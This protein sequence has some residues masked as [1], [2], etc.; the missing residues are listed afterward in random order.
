SFVTNNIDHVQH[1]DNQVTNQDI[2]L[3]NIIETNITKDYYQPLSFDQKQQEQNEQ[4]IVI[5]QINNIQNYQDVIEDLI[6]LVEK[7]QEQLNNETVMD[8]L[9][10]SSTTSVEINNNNNDDEKKKVLE[11]EQNDDKNTIN[12]FSFFFSSNIPNTIVIDDCTGNII[13]PIVNNNNNEKETENEKNRSKKEEQSSPNEPK[14]LFVVNNG[15]MSDDLK[16][17]GVIIEDLHED[18]DETIAAKKT[19]PT[20]Y[21]LCDDDDKISLSTT[22]KQR[23]L[24]FNTVLSCYEKALSNVT[25]DELSTSS[26]TASPLLMKSSSLGDCIKPLTISARPEDDPIAQRALRR[27]EERMKAAVAAKGS[28]NQSDLLAKGKSSWSGTLTTPRKSLDNLF[29]NEQLSVCPTSSMV[30]SDEPIVVDSYIRPRRNLFDNSDKVG[31]DYPKPLNLISSSSFNQRL[32]LNDGQTLDN[33]SKK[34]DD[35]AEQQA[36]V[37]I[38]NEDDKQ[39]LDSIRQ[40]KSS[41]SLLD[42]MSV[43]SGL[44]ISNDISTLT[45]SE[46]SLE[47]SITENSVSTNSSLN[48][49][50]SNSNNTDTMITSTASLILNESPPPQP[51]S[52]LIQ[53]LAPYRLQLEGRRRLNTLD[54]IKERRQSKENNID[55]THSSIESSVSQLQSEYTIKPEELQDPIIRRALERFDEKS[56]TLAQSKS[57]NYDDIQDPI[58]RRALTRLESNFK[59]TNIFPPSLPP[60]NPSSFVQMDHT[61]DRIPVD[62]GWYTNSY[63]MGTL[64]PQSTIADDSLSYNNHNRTSRCPTDN[65]NNKTTYVSVHQRFC[66]SSDNDQ[67]QSLAERDIPVLRVPTHPVYVSSSQQQQQ[68]QPTSQEERSQPIIQNSSLRQRSRSEDMLS[69]KQLE[70]TIGQTSN[71]DLDNE[72]DSSHEIQKTTSSSV[73]NDERQLIRNRSSDNL[74]SSSELVTNPNDKFLLPRS[75]ITS[76]ESNFVRTTESSLHYATP[77]KSYSAYSCEYTR[78]HRNLLTTDSTTT[79]PT[80]AIAS[81]KVSPRNT[82]D[83]LERSS[84]AS[85]QRSQPSIPQNYQTANANNQ[86]SH[87]PSQYNNTYNNNNHSSNFQQQPQ[88]YYPTSQS[89]SAFAPIRQTQS[90]DYYSREPSYGNVG[91]M[92]NT[93]SSTYSDDPIVRRALERFNS[94]MQ[95][96]MI[97][98]TNHNTYPYREPY[99]SR[100]YDTNSQ[101]T[102]DY[103]GGTNNFPYDHNSYNRSGY[104]TWSG[105]RS[106]APPL[107]QST[108]NYQSII[109]R[110]R[111]LRNDD[112]SITDSSGSEVGGG[113]NSSVFAEGDQRYHYGNTTSADIQPPI[114]PRFI[115]RDFRSEE[116]LLEP[117]FHRYLSEDFLDQ[118]ENVNN[119]NNNSAYIHHAYPATITN[120][121]TGF[122]PIDVN[123]Y[124]HQQYHHNQVQDY[125]DQQPNDITTYINSG[126]SSNINTNNNNNSD[127]LRDRAQSTSSTT[128]SD[129]LNTRRMIRPN[130]IRTIPTTQASNRQSTNLPIK[131]TNGRKQFNGNEQQQQTINKSLPTVEQNFTNRQS[132][133]ITPNYNGSSVVGDSVFHR[134]AYTGTKASLSKSNST[135]CSNLLSKGG[136][137]QSILKAREIDFDDTCSTITVNDN[138]TTLSS[139]NSNESNSKQQ[140]QQSSQSQS[141]QQQQQ[142]K[143]QRSRSVDGRARG[144][145]AQ[146]RINRADNDE[147]SSSTTDDN[148]TNSKIRVESKFT[149]NSNMNGNGRFGNGYV[150]INN[151]NNGVGRTTLMNRAAPERSAVLTKRT[152]SGLNLNSRNNNTTIN[153]RMRSSNSNLLDDSTNDTIDVELQSEC[154]ERGENDENQID[155]NLFETSQNAGELYQPKI[156]SAR[157]IPIRNN[158]QQSLSSSSITTGYNNRNRSSLER[159]DSNISI[160]DTN[161]LQK[162]VEIDRILSPNSHRRNIPVSV[163]VPAKTEKRPAPAPPQQQQQSTQISSSQSTDNSINFNQ[164][165]SPAMLTNGNN[166]YYSDD[167]LITS[168]PPPTPGVKSSIIPNSSSLSNFN[169]GGLDSTKQQQHDSKKMNVFERLFRGNKKKLE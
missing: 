26:A 74:Q 168:K 159:R 105:G 17:S 124:Q 112:T 37:N 69:T 97:S 8:V 94:Q 148:N 161:K 122:R 77:T 48:T 167:R 163:F 25:F 114:P 83:Y 102:R 47:N 31:L 138:E 96:S 16:Y 121:N 80:A 104:D 62:T 126:M 49:I 9:A 79:Q 34:E 24:P 136:A 89:S 107:P 42:T 59:R 56:R 55:D 155:N 11:E 149:N 100:N 39:E 44:G 72:N 65:G 30:R 45:D 111:Q 2:Q 32:S 75:M 70:L 76:L 125:N 38:N 145:T 61:Q 135:S 87:P 60:T 86:Q 120:T 131:L 58:T 165:Y 1:N 157:N 53:P 143:C 13:T 150:H 152:Q 93:S 33:T 21:I 154:N 160:S 98:S 6:H 166:S 123:D 73:N 164:Q 7:E 14:V 156:L 81:E 78:P 140:S 51:S 68:Q 106:V 147:N 115:R 134:L 50:M 88:Q 52:S 110:R 27:F 139:I 43:E 158:I 151:I 5:E 101:M 28:L 12:P 71:I 153:N 117:Q 146:A 113:Y 67:Q 4:S 29:K 90:N 66:A 10:K 141:Q 15:N 127:L 63:T 119:N 82:T 64:Q 99:S 130:N 116:Q 128:S 22:K 109:A 91:S 40:R 137:Q 20:D 103:Y 18:E 108:S 3:I 35:N 19:T 142:S 23:P 85:S 54:R 169:N 36:T 57:M 144:R 41:L 133:R 95:N 132:G 162:R 46:R 84:S 92:Y 118:N 129:S